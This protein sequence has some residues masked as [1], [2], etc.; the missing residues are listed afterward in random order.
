MVLGIVFLPSTKKEW[1]W[2]IIG[3]ILMGAVIFLLI[4]TGNEQYLDYVDNAIYW[5]W[6]AFWIFFSLCLVYWAIKWIVAKLKH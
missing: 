5:F 1:L 2:A 3:A 6:V 4:W